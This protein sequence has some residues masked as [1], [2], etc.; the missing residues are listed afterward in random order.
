MCQGTRIF[1]VHTVQNQL[2]LRAPVLSTVAV[3]LP[4]PH[5]LIYVSPSSCVCLVYTFVNLFVKP[6]RTLAMYILELKHISPS[7]VPSVW[8][9][10]ICDVRTY[11]V[12]S[13]LH[14]SRECIHRANVDFAALGVSLEG[15]YRN[16]WCSV[17][18][19]WSA[20]NRT[21][22]KNLLIFRWRSTKGSS[23]STGDTGYWNWDGTEKILL[24]VDRMITHNTSKSMQAIRLLTTFFPSFHCI[25]SVP[26]VTDCIYYITICRTLS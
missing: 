9:S 14:Q 7:F 8:R 2:N 1:H 13:G 21:L 18:R 16:V 17:A 22:S 20:R 12:S 5:V 4:G 10:D 3:L 15:K 11:L 24:L 23:S 6:K 19:V 26:P 25:Q